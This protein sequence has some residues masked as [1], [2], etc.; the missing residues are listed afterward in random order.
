MSLSASEV[1]IDHAL[2]LSW[3]ALDDETK[4]S[5]RVFLHDT[6]CVGVAGINAP[7]SDQILAAAKFWGHAGDDG[8][9][10]LGRTNIRLPAPQSAFVTAF[11]IHS[12]EFD[13]V[14]EPAVV[15]PLATIASVLLTEAERSGPYSGKEILLAL[16]AGVDVAAGLGI[17]A[18][19]GLKFFRPATAGVIG[20]AVALARLKKLDRQTALDAVGYA[21]AFA[22]GT[23]QAHVEGKPTLP[24][25][26]AAAA[27]SAIQAID[28]AAAGLPA[29][30]YAIEGPFGYLKLFEDQSDLQP[31]LDSLGKVYR[32]NEVSWKPF[33]T[34][35]AAHGAIVATEKLIA[36][37]D[38]RADQIERLEYHAPP[39][40]NRLVGRP[41]R[42]DMSAAYAR[43]CFPYLAGVIFTRGS[44]G[45][46]DF[47]S[48]RLSEKD[49]IAFGR[50]VE[51]FDNGNPDPAAFVPAYAIATLK[52]GRQ[53]RADVNA[54]FGSPE[55]KL[56]EEQH[57]AKAR[58]CLEFGG[59]GH[60]HDALV[61]L[62]SGIEDL[63][64][65]SGALNAVLRHQTR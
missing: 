3:E 22:S 49:V 16:I 15:H 45:L 51:V 35:R 30:L 41:V 20:S 25:Q 12:Q 17:A 46:G 26:I 11:Q 58:A 34:G 50:R 43:L 54:Q 27:R 18:K 14:H 42:D 23:M 59:A 9:H 55:W 48:E 52:D 5:A 31:V 29:P 57:L 37:H 44:V 36:E 28:I 47:T 1:F 40:I 24:V 62:V 6:I 56:T 32:I 10:V 38:L 60:C 8:C 39:L 13:C 4:L 65:F 21:V 19:T 63:D 53:V 64:D 61:E 33:P 2:S 7:H